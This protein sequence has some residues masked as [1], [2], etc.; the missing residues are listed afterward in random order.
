M[1]SIKQIDS[2]YY[3]AGLIEEKGVVIEAAPIIKWM[4]NKQFNYIKLYCKQR[5]YKII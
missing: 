5:N 3:C 1:R 4:I 2:G